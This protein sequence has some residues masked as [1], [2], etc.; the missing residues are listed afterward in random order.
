MATATVETTQEIERR[1]V[2]YSRRF[3]TFEQ[4]LDLAMGLDEHWEL[5]DGVM[6]ERIS[7]QFDHEKLLMRL[8]RILGIY[9]E[10][11]NLGI[12]LGSRSAV[13]I[14]ETDGRLPD[15]VFIRRERMDIILQR[16]IYGAPDLVAELTSP[17]DRPADTR[18]VE[19][20]Y[21]R[22]GVPEVWFV[23]QKRRSVRVLRRTDTGYDDVELRDG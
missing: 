7:A 16:A 14:S 1:R 20:D 15:L 19:L 8:N 6:V 23:D 3:T 17:S 21:R 22:I 10:E 12:V 4:F 13:E 18:R 5:V 11:R 2:R 9:V